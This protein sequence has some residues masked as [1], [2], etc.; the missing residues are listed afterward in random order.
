MAYQDLPSRDAFR[1]TGS[2][3]LD[4]TGV[5]I[6]RHHHRSTGPQ[7]FLCDHPRAAATVSHYSAYQALS[8]VAQEVLVNLVRHPDVRPLI[9]QR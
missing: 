9:Y 4:H 8:K 7:Q 3:T 6:N 5:G 1:E 2:G